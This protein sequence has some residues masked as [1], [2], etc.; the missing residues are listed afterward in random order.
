MPFMAI[1]NLCFAVINGKSNYKKATILSFT[2][3]ALVAFLIIF[4]VIFFQLS[5]VLL[6][7][8]LTPIVQIV[9]LMVFARPEFRLFASVRIG[10]HRLFKNN[11]FLFIIMSIAAVVLNNIVELQLRNHII[12]KLS[13]TEAGYWTSML[14][15]SSYYLSFTTGFYSLYVL[16]KFSK[17]NSLK[18]FK[19]ELSH[20]YRIIIPVFVLLFVG[21]YLFREII[22]QLLYTSEFLNMRVLFKWQL[23]GDLIKIIAIIMA[24]QLIAQRLWKLFI[25][26]EVISYVLFYI[27][28]VYFTEKMGVEGLVFAHFCRYSLYLI[29]IILLVPTF[30][31]NNKAAHES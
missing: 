21:I 15:L 4:L 30:F 24:Y 19:T 13:I 20:I 14:S 25:T 16:P 3:Y 8:T 2:A 10:F 12:K 9:V 26:T 23:M 22:I 17:M 6:A 7:V 28:G 5:G 18:E 11:L 29:M 1:Y 27:F 31:R